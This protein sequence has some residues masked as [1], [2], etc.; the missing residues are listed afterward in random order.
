M[1]A[2]ETVNNS[3]I[4]LTQRLRFQVVMP[5]KQSVTIFNRYMLPLIT[6]FQVTSSIQNQNLKIEKLATYI[7]RL[8]FGGKTSFVSIRERIVV[9]SKG[10]KGIHLFL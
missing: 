10:D 4:V 7:K 9:V 8:Q 3:C 1:L 6:L 2:N 5:F